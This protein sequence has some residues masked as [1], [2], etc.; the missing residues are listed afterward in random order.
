MPDWIAETLRWAADKLGLMANAPWLH[1]AAGLILNIFVA[2]IVW[3]LTDLP[4]PTIALTLAIALALWGFFAAIDN[5]E[6]GIVVSLAAL[7]I[8]LG[9]Q[10]AQISGKKGDD[11]SAALKCAEWEG[12]PILNCKKPPA[13]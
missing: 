7:I 4:W 12:Q 11:A 8:G 9:F 13:K 6:H 3:W 1:P 5:R 10:S 2:I